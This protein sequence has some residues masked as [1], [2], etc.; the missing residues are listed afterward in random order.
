M[1]ND[2]YLLL[3]VLLGCSYCKTASHPWLKTR[4]KLA[5][6]YGSQGTQIF[7][8]IHHPKGEQ[9]NVWDQRDREGEKEREEVGG[10]RE[11]IMPS[12]STWIIICYFSTSSSG[13]DIHFKDFLYIRFK[14]I[15][16]LFI[17][18]SLFVDVFVCIDMK[19]NKKLINSI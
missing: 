1:F 11:R 8:Q 5:T 14:H 19:N 7:Y 9:K 2:Y 3:L 13:C 12:L 4:Q 18:I 15:V 6:G 10:K 16:Y 17:R